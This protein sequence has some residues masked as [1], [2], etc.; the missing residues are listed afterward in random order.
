MSC[1]AVCE[2]ILAQM[3]HAEHRRGFST[4]PARIVEGCW[5]LGLA[6]RGHPSGWPLRPH[7][8]RHGPKGSSPKTSAPTRCVCVKI[9]WQLRIMLFEADFVTP[10]QSPP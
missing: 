4:V 1:F 2:H 3:C 8:A 7:T 9:S 5:A 10:A 6:P